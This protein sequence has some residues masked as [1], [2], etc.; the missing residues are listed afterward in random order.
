MLLLSIDIDVVVV[1]CFFLNC[2]MKVARYTRN[3]LTIFVHSV[4]DLRYML[5][6]GQK[7]GRK[8]PAKAKASKKLTR[9]PIFHFCVSGARCGHFLATSRPPGLPTAA[10]I[11][12]ECSATT[13]DKTTRH[14][15]KKSRD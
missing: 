4:H 15:H 9:L 14:R 1:K 2:D 5:L 7:D 3:K 13:L 10:T 12:Q 8:E 6:G 11:Q